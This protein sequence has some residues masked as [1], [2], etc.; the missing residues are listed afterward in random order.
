MDTQDYF[1]SKI[2]LTV[3]HILLDCDDFSHVRMNHYEEN[4]MRELFESVDPTLIL[5]FLKE[6]GLFY[7]L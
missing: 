4:D 6:I 7:R 2:P 3:K 5:E 1:H